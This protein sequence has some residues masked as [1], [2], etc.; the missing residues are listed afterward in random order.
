MRAGFARFD[1]VDLRLGCRL[2]GLSQDQ[3]QV[4][5]TDEVGEQTV[6][7]RYVIASDVA[8]LFWK[9]GMVLRGLAPDQLLDLYQPEREPHV[10]GVIGAAV[11]AGRYISVLDP[12]EAAARDREMRV[13]MADGSPR[14]AADLIPPLESGIVQPAIWGRSSPSPL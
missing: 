2:T 9:L 1:N 12:A 8:N 14:T 13:R 4:T 5:L 7:A 6:S 10:R 11:A 3:G